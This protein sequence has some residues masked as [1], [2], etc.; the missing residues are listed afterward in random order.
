MLRRLLLA[1][2]AALLAPLGAEA[3][4]AEAA[5]HEE[6]RSARQ[7]AV[8]DAVAGSTAV[9]WIP[10]LAPT[11]GAGDAGSLREWTTPPDRGVRSLQGGVSPASSTL[12]A[13]SRLV[14]AGHLSHHLD[15]PP[16]SRD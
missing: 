16:P 9:P 3:G 11:A 8:H 6:E 1:F 2:A 4:I 14:R 7:T 13:E 5:G 15:L 10:T 12:P